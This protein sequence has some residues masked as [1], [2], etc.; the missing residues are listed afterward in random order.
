MFTEIL[1]VFG[2]C[3]AIL[4]FRSGAH[5]VVSAFVSDKYTKWNQVRVLSATRK[6]NRLA[7]AWMTLQ[8]ISSAVYIG[9]LQYM[10]NTVKSV[11]RQ[12]CIVSYVIAGKPYRMVVKPVRGAS[13]VLQVSDEESRDVTSY[14]LPFMGPSYDWHGMALTP[15]FFHTQSLTFEF[16]NGREITCSGTGTRIP[17]LVDM[18]N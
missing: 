14:V 5:Q 2:T 9:F 18:E 8:M 4:L 16:G 17:C 10:N 7:I 15:Q 3:G 6:T 12:T 11:D 13:R 1:F